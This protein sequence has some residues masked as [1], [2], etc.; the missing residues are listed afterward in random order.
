MSIQYYITLIAVLTILVILTMFRDRA[1]LRWLTVGISLALT[2]R[3]LY[4]RVNYTLNDS[5]TL[6]LTI[7][8]II[9]LA[10][11]YGLFAALFFYFQVAAPTKPRAHVS[12][13]PALPSVDIYVTCYDESV[14]IVRRTLIGCQDIE[15]P[16]HKKNLYLLDDGAR[17]EM[18]TLA[19]RLGCGYL[20]RSTRE[21]AKAGNLNNALAH[22]G[23]EFICNFDADHIPVKTF[24][25][26]T[27][28]FFSEPKVALVQTPHYFYN[29]DIYQR[30]LKMQN[31]I[32][33]EQDL[34]FQ[35][36]QPGRD[37]FNAS[38][39]CGSGAVFRRQA[40]VQVGGFATSSVTEDIHTT[41]LIHAAG[42]RSVYVR[43]VLAVGLSPESFESYLVQRKRWTKGHLQIF[44]SKDNPLFLKGLS[45]AQRIH[46][47]AS[48]YYF[49][50]GPAR[51][52][53]LA[54]PLFFLL[55]S[56]PPLL[57]TLPDMVNFFG[58]HYVAA[59]ISF[60][61]MV[62]KHR[63]PF[64]SDVYEAVMC[65]SLTRTLL[66]TLSRPKSL[67]FNVTPKGQKFSESKMDVQS[68]FPHF[69]L[70]ALLGTGMI[71]GC[72]RYILEPFALDALVISLVLGV[73]NL[74]VL[75]CAV[76]AGKESVQKRTSFRLK[77][78]M[79]CELEYDQQ[80]IPARTSDISE[81]GVAIDHDQPIFLPSEMTVHLY[82]QGEN[83]TLKGLLVRND[84]LSSG[85]SSI[86]IRFAPMD[87]EIYHRLT[88]LIYTDPKSWKV[89]GLDPVGFVRSLG[90]LVRAPISTFSNL[91]ILRRSAPR[92]KRLLEAQLFI[93]GQS[94]RAGVEDV[95]S[96]G[97]RLVVPKEWTLFPETMHVQVSEGDR[98]VAFGEGQ[99]AWKRSLSN[100]TRLG[101]RWME[102]K[103]ELLSI[104]MKS[105][106]SE[107]D[108]VEEK[109][110]IDGA[111]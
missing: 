48:I 111:K 82:H 13:H 16:E 43:D 85:K 26:K 83:V 75:S 31:K 95:G 104:M 77:R 71:L 109:S 97:L 57:A 76:F 105:K 23:G 41:M 80:C 12:D 90:D 21:H 7:S 52:V 84:L 51:I 29:P 17:E 32:A 99:L 47:F 15:Y 107:R 72:Y 62:G 44:L 53:F 3:Y 98:V 79:V 106:K 49:M 33:H 40:L 5:D 67:F 87:P 36:I 63:N 35:V 100:E 91:K 64:W 103:P 38:F 19:G 11:V 88:S 34:F 28:G 60:H 68:T 22:S 93:E 56:I 102:E 8:V 86:G 73:Y 66:E 10:E 18:R 59:L 69:I 6:S 20:S 81:E 101:V 92:I 50:L 94:V 108:Q 96:Q 9:L 55:F 78:E 110:S 37:Y 45:F 39:Y 61:L 1:A 2:F 27:M 58:S 74:F 89:S 25:K 54:V 30:N 42:Y 4:W 24:L 46:Y 14:D 65:F 70:M